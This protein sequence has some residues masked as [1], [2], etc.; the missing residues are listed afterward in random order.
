MNLP[1]KAIDF[2][3]IERK[4]KIVTSSRNV[5]MIFEK[6]HNNVLRDIENIIGGLLKIEQSNQIASGIITERDVDPENYFRKSRY[7]NSQNKWQ[8]EYL[9]TR[10]GFDLTVMGFTGDKALQYKVAYVKKFEEMEEQL[11]TLQI[12]RM[13]FP[14]LT[15]AIKQS[16]EDPKPYHFSNEIN[17]INKIVLGMTTKKFRELHGIKKNESI[18][19]Y[20]TAE[21]IKAIEQLQKFD[22]GL[23]HTEPDYHKRKEILTAYYE[24]ISSIRLIG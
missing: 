14:Q 23:I 17:M 21:Q 19:P 18:R 13:E 10:K 6:R 20:L 5:A 12:A 7:K 1:A 4:G 11:Q 8:P 24:R 15:D 9:M 16:K 2:G 22:I 3:V